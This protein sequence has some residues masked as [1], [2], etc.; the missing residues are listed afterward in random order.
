MLH[1]FHILSLTMRRPVYRIFPTDPNVTTIL[2]NKQHQERV[3]LNSF[4][5]NGHILMIST[6][7]KAIITLYSI[8]TAPLRS[9]TA[10]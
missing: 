9:R 6:D 7:L 5:L 1:N 10:Q 4:N 2:Y 8:K 3:L